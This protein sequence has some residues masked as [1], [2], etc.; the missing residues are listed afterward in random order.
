MYDASA[1]AQEKAPWINECLHTG[2]PLQN[3]LWSVTVR[4][5]LHPVAVAGD[6][7]RVFLQVRIRETERDALRFHWIADK[8]AKQVETVYFT[9]VV[10]G[11]APS[12]FLLNG[13]IQQHLEI[14]QSRYPDT[15]NEIRKSLYVDD[16]ISGGPTTDKAKCSK[17]EATEIFADA[18]FELHKWHSNEKELETSCEDYEPSLAKEQLEN[19][20]P[21]GECKLLGI[22]WDKV[23]DTL[24]VF[25]PALPAEETK[26]GILTNLAKVYDPLGIVSP[27]MLEGKLLYRDTCD[28]KK[29][30][31]A[32][33]PEEIADQWRKWE[34]GLPKA[35]SVKCSIPLYHEEID[36]IQ[37]HAFGDASGRGVCAAVY[38]MVMQVSGVSQGLITAKSRLAKQGLTILRLE[39]VSGH[40]AVNLAANVGEA[41]EGLPLATNVHCWL[42]S[43][44][45]LHWIGDRGEYRQFVANHMEKIQTHPNVL[46]HHV[47]STDNPADLG[48]RGGSVIGAQLWWNGPSW[49]ADPTKWPPEVVTEPSPE[50][51][52]ERK[53][54][55]ELFVVGRQ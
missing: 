44:V 27:V 54:Q 33:L 37:L 15:V 51:A 3:K 43:S 25:F 52:A 18:K 48:S 26:R 7:R 32:P 8:T 11:L 2:P 19:E 36:E 49:L 5:R 47:P 28:Q 31:D 55:Q 40:M 34:R 10:F 35:E 39:L 23:D 13:V 45:A 14:L 50:S 24:H 20:A 53:V 29:A 38:A 16:L 17:H 22:G 42:D 4:N 21:K 6:L 30:W 12:P 46:W 1:R 41:L 9:R